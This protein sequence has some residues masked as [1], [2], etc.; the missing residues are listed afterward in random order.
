MAPPGLAAGGAT[1]AFPRQAGRAEEITGYTPQKVPLE[2]SGRKSKMDEAPIK[3]AATPWPALNS[4]EAAL[5]LLKVRS[6]LP[7]SLVSGSPCGSQVLELSGGCR[8]TRK[9]MGVG[10]VLWCEERGGCLTLLGDH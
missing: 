9:A 3:N 5:W 4:P 6:L 8:S 2:E 10:F 7:E 1:A